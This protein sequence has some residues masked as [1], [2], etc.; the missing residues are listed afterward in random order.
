MK[1]YV[2]LRRSPDW[3]SFD[4]A[5]SRAFCATF[6]DNH[7]LII[8][9]AA[10]WDAASELD[11]LHYR[12]AMKDLSLRSAKGVKMAEVVSHTDP[13]LADVADDDLLFFTDDDDWVRPDIFERLRAQPA[14][15]DGWLW[16]S[17]FVGK[18]FSDTPYEKSDGYIVQE[19]D[20]S[21]VVYTNNYAVTGRAWKRLGPDALLEHFSTQRTLN[22]GEIE[23]ERIDEF[24]SAANK[25]I[26]CTVSIFH[27]NR[28]EGFTTS[29]PACVAQ[30]TAEIE[31]VDLPT[32]SGWIQPYIEGLA[33]TNRAVLGVA[34]PKA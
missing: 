18:M 1:N 17:I 27:N 32:H 34:A 8:D 24:L 20:A 21:D 28:W 5:D 26:C 10:A 3:L 14:A 23:L 2:V 9:F 33:E 29:L 12:Q 22:A 25:H 16:R 11:F 19:R 30:I 4:L 31:A 15:E 7:D 13:D 6:T